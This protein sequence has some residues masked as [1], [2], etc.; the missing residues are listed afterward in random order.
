[1]PTIVRSVLEESMSVREG[2]RVRRM[3]AFEAFVRTVLRRAFK[4]DPKFVAALI[5]LMRQ[6]GLASDPHDGQ[7][8][9][10]MAS[11]YQTIISEFHA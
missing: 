6:F 1:M 11:D 2:T 4:G 9:L 10:L 3:S 5:M 8:D 7:E